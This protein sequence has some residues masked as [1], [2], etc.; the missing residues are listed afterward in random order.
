LKEA[1][2]SGLTNSKCKQTGYGTMITSNMICASTPDF[3]TDACQGDS[4]GWLFVFY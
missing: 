3:D 2:V 1:F 4:G